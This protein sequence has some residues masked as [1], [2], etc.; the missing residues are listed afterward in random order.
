[1][2]RSHSIRRHLQSSWTQ[3]FRG[4]RFGT[5]AGFSI[6]A[7]LVVDP[8]PCSP[9]RRE[10]RG[11]FC[12]LLHRIKGRFH[13]VSG[14]CMWQ[15]CWGCGSTG[16]SGWLPGAQVSAE[17][18]LRRPGQRGKGAG[19]RN[20][21][22]GAQHARQGCGPSSDLWKQLCAPHSASCY[23]SWQHISEDLGENRPL[24]TIR[25]ILSGV[26]PGRGGSPQ[27]WCKGGVPDLG[28][29]R[30][31]SSTSQCQSPYCICCRLRQP[32]HGDPRVHPRQKFFRC[33]CPVE[34]HS[35]PSSWA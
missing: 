28:L 29:G 12:S 13:L 16:E 7:A 9:T 30:W 32:G 14:R 25:S 33:C 3:Q 15:L 8:T 20:F 19:R 21:G 6:K 23:K 35:L 34:D 31:V 24:G 27:G 5:S 17:H 4:F 10:W 22:S 26:L 18:R 2:K 11:A 1:M